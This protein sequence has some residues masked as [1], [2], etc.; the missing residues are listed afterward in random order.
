METINFKVRSNKNYLL[1]PNLTIVHNLVFLIHYMF[2][3][4]AKKNISYKN[5]K[6][7]MHY[8]LW[9]YVV[10][11]ITIYI[12]IILLYPYF[13]EELKA[14][15][16]TLLIPIHF[17][18]MFFFPIIWNILWSGMSLVSGKLEASGGPR[19][20]TALFLVCSV[21]Q[22]VQNVCLMTSKGN[23][24]ESTVWVPPILK[25]INTPITPIV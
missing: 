12:L 14:L 3:I 23:I 22:T 17:F 13:K 20:S 9:Q 2:L 6:K 11:Q 16:I 10:I 1:W 25:T 18:K 19:G 21:K 5:V 15:N 24:E 8:V 7:C 4:R